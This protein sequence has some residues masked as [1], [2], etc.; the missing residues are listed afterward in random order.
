MDLLMKK[1]TLILA[2]IVMLVTGNVH[3]ATVKYKFTIDTKTVNFTGAPV[4]ALAINKQIPGPTITATVGDILEVTFDN[5]M[6][7]ET[8]IHW[9]GIL[10]PNE[11]DGVPYLTTQP[12]APHS[13]FTYNYKITHAGTYWYHSHTGLQEQ[14]GI[15]GAL[16]FHPKNGA[17]IKTDRDYVVVLSDWINASPKQVLANLKQDGDYYALKKGSVQSWDKVIK[18]GFGAIKKRL[19]GAWSRMGPMDL[20]DVRVMMHFLPMANSSRI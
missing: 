17:R 14:R 18:N 15:Y 9:H 3:A 10:L 2:F 12:I 5:K 8:S 4:V 11:Q 6:D 13:S 16:V 20:S 1:Y 19:Q 7:V